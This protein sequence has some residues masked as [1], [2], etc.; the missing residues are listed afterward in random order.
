MS[1]S[2]RLK[3]KAIKSAAKMPEPEQEALKLLIIELETYGPVRGNWPNY[4]KLGKNEHHCHLSHRWV[5]CWRVENGQTQIVEIYYAGSRKD[6][7]Y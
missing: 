6:A 2:V 3:K 4:S 7:P 5:V 1:W